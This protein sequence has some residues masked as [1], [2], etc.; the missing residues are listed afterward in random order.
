MTTG[1]G[2]RTF[3]E[4]EPSMQPQVGQASAL[5]TGGSD[6]CGSLAH[7]AGADGDAEASAD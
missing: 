5:R 3:E 7:D 4:L 1:G 6:P 2:T